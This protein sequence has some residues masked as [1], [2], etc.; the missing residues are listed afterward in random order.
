MGC[1][2]TKDLGEEAL[3]FTGFDPDLS[4]KNVATVGMHGL[5]LCAE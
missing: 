5:L 4:G 2:G 3:L 1:E